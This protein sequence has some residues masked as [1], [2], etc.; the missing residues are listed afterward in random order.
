M[1]G[2]HRTDDRARNQLWHLPVNP[3]EPTRATIARAG[4]ALGTDLAATSIPRWL[5][6]SLGV[7]SPLLREVAEMAYQWQAPFILD[8]SRFRTTFGAAATPWDRA[9]ADTAAWAR[10]HYAVSAHRAA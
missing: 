7:F 5:L 4:R 6:R 1:P 10:A 3:A 2:D 8:D 9:M